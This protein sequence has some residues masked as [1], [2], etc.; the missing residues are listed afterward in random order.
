MN[1]LS[2]GYSRIILRNVLLSTILVTAFVVSAQVKERDRERE[3]NLLQLREQ[4]KQA[5]T[6]SDSIPIL[7][8]LFD[9]SSG[10]ESATDY[11]FQLYA[12]AKRAGNDEVAF[13]ALRNIASTNYKNDS[14]LDVTEKNI[15]SFK[16]SDDQLHTLTF[17]RVMRDAGTLQSTS[18]EH[19][20]ERLQEQL[21]ELSVNPPK[22]LYDRI[23][24]LH[25]ICKNLAN[26]SEGELLAE[27]LQELG[28]LIEQVPTAD[29]ALKTSYYV[30]S[31]TIYT[32]THQHKL[33]IEACLK[34]LDVMEQLD[35]RN[36]QMG[37]IYKS[38]GANRYVI[39]TRLLENYE[40]LTKEEIEKYYKLAMEE[41]ANTPQAAKTYSSA[42]LPDIYYAYYKKD[43]QTLFDLIDKCKN[44]PYLAPKRLQ[45]MRMYIEA[46]ENIGR[47][48][49][50]LKTYSEYVNLLEEEMDSRQSERFRELQVIYEV[51]EIK[52]ENERLQEQES[53][54]RSKIWVTYIWVSV[55]V[56]L[57][58]IVFVVILWRMGRRSQL[59]ATQLTQANKALNNESKSLREARD[60]LEAARDM[61]RNADALK[62]D[63][64]AN[65][66]HEVKVP[67]QN[68]QEYSEMIV[69][70]ADDSKKK[71]LSTF[72]DRLALNCELVNTIVNDVL[73]LSELSNSTVKIKEKPCQ[74][75]EVCESAIDSLGIRVEPDVKMIMRPEN[76]G[77][78]IA[79]ADDFVLVTDRH[80][81]IQILGNLLS[82]A[83]KFTTE[84]EIVLTYGKSAD[85][86]QAVFTVTDTGKGIDPKF[87][88]L[89]F[90]RFAKLDNAFPGAGLG[91]TISRMLAELLGGALILDTAYTDGARF[92]L[93]LPL[94]RI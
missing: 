76:S 3:Q 43:Y 82:N 5:K 16:S 89:I 90:E 31:S 23:V 39:Y 81:L 46:A 25:S 48:D 68:I 47:N 62:T 32:K 36:K 71:F 17:I 20:S 38:Y 55:G 77:S 79:G 41:V 37:R 51:N 18:P 61:A 8:N 87:K 80:R 91:L 60:Q 21:R 52:A 27:Y 26:I 66:S 45:I 12:T 53:N 13:D 22:D 69:E 14:I 86:S 50:L 78:T 54:T 70:N 29:R 42:P 33:A 56:V 6:G 4:L 63:F 93:T 9:I 64:I 15:R 2:P 74:V 19:R 72:A 75:K 11:A 44:D 1:W 65:M 85:L 35:E 58:L 34:L 28:N 49:A 57:I 59:L 88:N 73:Q 94:R 24:L 7:Y 10:R 67:L 84:G 83:A 92:I 30:W 40:G